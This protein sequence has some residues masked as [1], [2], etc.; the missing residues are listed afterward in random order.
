MYKEI[1][2]LI[3][4]GNMKE[5]TILVKLGEIFR[6]FDEKTEDNAQLIRD[7]YTQLKRLL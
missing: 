1:A 6:A 3:M 2:K 4:Y 5:D 7:I